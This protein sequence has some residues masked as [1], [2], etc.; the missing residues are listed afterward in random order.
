MCLVPGATEAAVMVAVQ[1]VIVAAEKKARDRA[2]VGGEVA[3]RLCLV[4]GA[5]EAAVMVAVQVVIVA[6]EKK[7]RDQALVEAGIEGVV[8]STEVV[9]A[10]AA[11][12]AVAE[13]RRTLGF[14]EAAAY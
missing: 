6:V 3:V 2:L 12:A 8:V 14:V 11:V 13:G 5:T 7:T 1:V 4:P 9:M 10:E